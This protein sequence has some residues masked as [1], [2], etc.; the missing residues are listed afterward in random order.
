MLANA[1][2][3]YAHF[4]AAFGIAAT[5]F[6]EWF[7]YS[8]NLTAREARRLVLADRWYGVFAAALLVAGFTRAA[9]FEKGWSFYAQ[10]P[11]FHAKLTLFILI[12]LLSVYPTIRFLKWGPDLKAGRAPQ[13]TDTQHRM[14]SSSLNAEIV[15]LVPL[16]LC[17]S[18]MAKGV[19]M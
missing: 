11:L 3:A 1:L 10:S 8:R 19:G 4:V 13:V 5:L 9:L 12:G 15:L 16:L 14:I 6:F 2:V 18:L 17:A 7:T